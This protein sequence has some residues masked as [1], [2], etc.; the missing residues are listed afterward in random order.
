MAKRSRKAKKQAKKRRRT[1]RTRAPR[2]VRPA[3]RTRAAT[4]PRGT[5]KPP[6]GMAPGMQAVNAHL[7][8]RNVEQALEFCERA[9]GFKRRFTVPGPDGGL[10]HA[11]LS[12]GD[13]VVMLGPESPRSQPP[14]S[15]GK[16]PVTLYVYVDDVDVVTAQ[17]REAGATIEED[18]KDQFWGDRA[19]VIVDP[20]GHRWMLATFKKLVAP[21][22]MHPPGA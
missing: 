18:P 10:T 1:A 6:G 13:A 19:S 17:A 8:V 9:L 16:S 5:R 12:H 14:P 15:P 2:R 22:D 21:E 20:S 7:T 4:R 11:E 3:R